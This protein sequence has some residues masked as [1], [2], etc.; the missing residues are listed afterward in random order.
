MKTSA[1]S[2]ALAVIAIPTFPASAAV[3]TL[4]PTSSSTDLRIRRIAYQPDLVTTVSARPDFETMI[5]F[6]PGERIENVA[7]GDSTSWQVV[8][9]KHSDRLFVKPVS[10]DAHTN[11]AV[12]T[13][14]RTYLFEL[15]SDENAGPIMYI[16]RFTYPESQ[17]EKQTATAVP[18]VTTAWRASGALALRPVRVYDDGHSVFLYWPKGNALPAVLAVGEKGAEEPLSFI[19]RD[20]YLITEGVPAKILVRVGSN[21]AV[22]VPNIGARQAAN[23]IATR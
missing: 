2:L 22:L 14:Q 17:I 20:D 23:Q 21:Q 15:R 4:A 10:I 6:A 1:L 3:P 19:A 5:S 12:V 11:M 16:L 13:D 7:V 18:A 9:N 8:P